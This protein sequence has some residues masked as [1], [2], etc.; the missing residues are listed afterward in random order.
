MFKIA[1]SAYIS[2][3]AVLSGDVTIGENSSVYFNAAIR[4]DAGP[5]VI[6]ERSNVQDC[7]V[8]HNATTI[9]DDVSIGHSAIVHGCTIGNRVVVGMGSIIMDNAVI[10][11]D[12]LIGAGTLITGGTV[13]PEKSL[14]FG[15]P[16]KVV[17]SLEEKDLAYIMFDSTF[18]ADAG[19]KYKRGEIEIYRAEK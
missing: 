3:S 10:G 1:E 17:R 19:Q 15:R 5:I 2:D 9:G 6:G 7:C 14:V 18:Y 13:I 12:C 16:G 11:D 8:I 4:G